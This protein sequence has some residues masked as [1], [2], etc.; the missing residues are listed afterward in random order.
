[1]VDANSKRF[2]CDSVAPKSHGSLLLMQ[3]ESW[4]SQADAPT[5]DRTLVDRVLPDSSVLGVL[6]AV[7]L[8]LYRQHK[9]VMIL[10]IYEHVGQYVRQHL[11]T[12][13][14]EQ[15]AADFSPS[16]PGGMSPNEFATEAWKHL[17]VRTIRAARGATSKST[18]LLLHPR[19]RSDTSPRGQWFDDPAM[20]RVAFSR[21]AH[22][23]HR[24]W[25]PCP[26][27]RRTDGALLSPHARSACSRG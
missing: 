14:L 4:T 26:L 6:A 17:D 25:I 10:T 23:R 9:Q 11:T 15:V 3:P 5:V 22:G 21:R 12:R 2:T 1:M 20:R 13:L 16:L 7:T 27:G 24:H 18:I 8:F 19:Y